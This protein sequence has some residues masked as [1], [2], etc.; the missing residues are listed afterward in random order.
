MTPADLRVLDAR[1][2][3]AYVVLCRAG[4]AAAEAY[5]APTDV[6]AERR[7]DMDAACSAFIA[8]DL[9]TR[10]AR[11]TTPAAGDA[12]AALLLAQAA[13]QRASV[14]VQHA[15]AACVDAEA[16]YTAALRARDA[17]QRVLGLEA[18]AFRDACTGEP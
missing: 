12:Y 14:A 10:E 18:R 9:A 16:V 2:E 6:R 15:A 3:A 4:G 7:A 17:A 11:A 1:R 8:A 13:D 5:Y